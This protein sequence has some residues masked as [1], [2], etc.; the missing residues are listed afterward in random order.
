MHA[1]M[2]LAHAVSFLS[3]HSDTQAAKFK[4]VGTYQLIEL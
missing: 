2:K 4:C 1:F 3:I